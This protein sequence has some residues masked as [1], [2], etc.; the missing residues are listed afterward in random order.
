MSQQVYVTNPRCIMIPNHSYNSILHVL[1]K[2][3]NSQ[4]ENIF[5]ENKSVILS[6]QPIL[7]QEEK[8]YRHQYVQ[9]VLLCL[10][11][12]HLQPSQCFQISVKEKCKINI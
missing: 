3:G 8:Q 6:C 12:G 9:E 11:Q 10:E 5:C 4:S 1:N 7:V 2:Q